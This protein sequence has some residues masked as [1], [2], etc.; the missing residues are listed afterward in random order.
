M[1]KKGPDVSVNILTT[2]RDVLKGYVQEVEVIDAEEEN[3]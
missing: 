1:A 3:N 2:Q